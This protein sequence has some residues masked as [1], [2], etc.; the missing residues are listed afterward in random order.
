MSF[1]PL[2]IYSPQLGPLTRT[3]ID[4]FMNE[5]LRMYDVPLTSRCYRLPTLDTWILTNSK[6][7][8]LVWINGPWVRCQLWRHT[9]VKRLENIKNNLQT[10]VV[11]SQ[12]MFQTIGPL[13]W[14][15]ITKFS[16]VKAVS[17]QGRRNEILLGGGMKG[18]SRSF[19][20]ILF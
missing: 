20:N 11:Y 14:L 2:G 5:L 9:R 7:C 6:S 8:T 13:H 17:N 4:V 12:Q 16:L 18:G 3:I 15:I 10:N 1:N 19:W